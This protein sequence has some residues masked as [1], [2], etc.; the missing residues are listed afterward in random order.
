MSADL[1]PVLKA[2]YPQVVASL[3]RVLGDIDR[4]MDATQ[5]ALVK[6]LQKWPESGVP[7]Q[8]VA[9]LVT[10]GRNGAIDV[11]RRDAKVVSIDQGN[12][13]ERDIGL[14]DDATIE[15]N[16]LSLSEIDDDLLR[17]MFVCCDPVLTPTSQITLILKVVLGFSVEEIA[18]ALL[19]SPGNVEKRI[20]RAKQKIKRQANGYP[21]PRKEDIPAR[22][23]S[24]LQAIYLLFNEGYSRVQDGNLQRSNLVDE[25]IRLARIACRLIRKHPDPR[26]LLALMLLNTARMPARMDGHG[27]L[28]PLLEQ[29]RKRWDANLTSEGLALVDAVFFARHPPSAY[30]I[31][32]AISALHNK[33]T[34]ADT[35]DWHQI[36][37]LY[38]KLSELD[39]SPVVVINWAA[40]L[41]MSEDPIGALQ[42]LETLQAQPS[43]DRYQPY[44][45]ARAHI[46]SQLGQQQEAVLS[47]KKAIA[48]AGS[49]PQK[50]YLQSRL[51]AIL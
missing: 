26:S 18:R 42:R 3:T 11:L 41:S 30:Q 24:V 12:S 13:L 21:T 50:N 16:E 44:H 35:T 22:L 14:E 39:P 49:I 4:A 29:D 1:G 51:Q 17:L 27:E 9:W 48:L 47:Y 46:L 19:S 7:D 28:V 34:S 36:V 5:D 33:A 45:A 32:A 6:A 43:I 31:Q 40:A 8:P 25:A 2:A 15:V 38:A 37:G 23:N 20:T 10:V